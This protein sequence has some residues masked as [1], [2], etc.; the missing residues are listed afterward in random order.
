MR[1]VMMKAQELAEAILS[2]ETY[3]K[4]KQL[5]LLQVIEVMY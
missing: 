5:H 3:Q 2:S 4:M 1:E